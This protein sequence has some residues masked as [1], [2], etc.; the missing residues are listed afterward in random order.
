VLPWARQATDAL[1][2]LDEAAG[3]TRAVG[4]AAMGPEIL[5]EHAL[6]RAVPR[7]PK[8]GSQPGAEAPASSGRTGTRRSSYPQE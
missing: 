8:P 1:L 4:K 3:A 5:A 6:S 2:A 7:F